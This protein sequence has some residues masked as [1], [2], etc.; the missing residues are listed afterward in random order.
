[1]HRT[2]RHPATRS[3]AISTAL[4]WGERLLAERGA[5]WQA[6][7]D[8][9]ADG[10]SNDRPQ[11]REVVIGEVTVNALAIGIGAAVRLE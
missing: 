9:N 7:L 1:M 3:I 5:C 11:P 10:T 4:G 8:L 2:G 6:T